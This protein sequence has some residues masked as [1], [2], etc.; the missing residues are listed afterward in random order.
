MDQQTQSSQPAF[1]SDMT[2]QFTTFADSPK[3][4]KSPHISERSSSSK[5]NKKNHYH[6]ELTATNAMQTLICDIK[7]HPLKYLLPQAL[8]PLMPP[9]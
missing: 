3:K 9:T 5:L 1:N 2:E 4:N 7:I 6:F 8:L